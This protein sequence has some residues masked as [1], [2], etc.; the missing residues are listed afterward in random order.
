MPQQFNGSH[1]S[2]KMAERA[3]AKS[4]EIALLV[5]DEMMILQEINQFPASHELV[6]KLEIERF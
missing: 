1:T 4:V 2:T 3:R 6:L 5:Y